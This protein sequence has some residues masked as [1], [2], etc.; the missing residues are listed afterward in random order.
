M[1]GAGLLKHHPCDELLIR[2]GDGCLFC[3]WLDGE[4]YYMIFWLSL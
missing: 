2:V 1:K 4:F 3:S